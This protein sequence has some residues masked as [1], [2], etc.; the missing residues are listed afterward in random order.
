[1]AV[2][3]TI[4]EHRLEFYSCIHLNVKRHF[5]PET[6]IEEN[7]TAAQP[8]ESTS[9]RDFFPTISLEI[10]LEK[11]HTETAHRWLCYYWRIDIMNRACLN[12]F[13]PDCKMIFCDGL[14]V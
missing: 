13:H 2:Q 7:N 11:H 8:R 12:P 1:M 4:L 6:S 3:E 5:F 10:C 14:K 9:G